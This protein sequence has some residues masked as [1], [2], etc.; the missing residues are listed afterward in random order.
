MEPEAR[1]RTPTL[2]DSVV[3]L[4]E[5]NA[6]LKA[7]IA[8]L[9]ATR[10]TERPSKSRRLKSSIMSPA[11]QCLMTVRRLILECARETQPAD[12]PALFAELRDELGDI[13]KV[14]NERETYLVNEPA[15]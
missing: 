11:E 7:H 13:E 9:E 14:A 6:A 5:E 2:K 12:L 10:E 8:E 4:E 1:T 3:A 15:P